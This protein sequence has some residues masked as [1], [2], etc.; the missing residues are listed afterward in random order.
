[1]CQESFG[2]N[3]TMKNKLEGHVHVHDGLAAIGLK[4]I[5]V[6]DDGL[7]FIGKEIAD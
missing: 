3:V 4:R 7:V 6:E 1:M 2:L 5:E